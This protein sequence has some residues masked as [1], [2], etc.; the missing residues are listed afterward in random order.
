MDG[1]ER[2]GGTAVDAGSGALLALILSQQARSRAELERRSGLSRAT[3]AQRLASLFAAGLVR[4]DEETRATG[5]RPA[6]MLVLD[7]R[8]ACV[9]A[10]DIGETHLSVA[11]ADLAPRI[12][13]RTTVAMD[14]ASGPEPILG[15]IATAAAALLDRHAVPASR[16]LGLGLSLPAP[17]NYGRGRVAGPSVMRAW[18]DFDIGGW[19]GGRLGIA[20]FAD[21]DVNLMALAEHR[22]HWPAVEHFFYIKVGTGIGS[23]IITEGRLFRG[24]QGAAGDIGHIQLATTRDPPLCR[25]GKL[26]CV[27]ARAAGWAIA[28]DLT[29]I[30]HPATSARDVVAILDRGVPDAIR[31]VRGAARVVGEVAA[32]IV[33]VLN[34]QVIVI[35][36]TMARAEEHLLAGV[37]ELVNQRCLPL[38]T[39]HLE[40][41][42]ARQR[43]DAGLIGAAE[44]VVAAQLEPQVI[45]A[46]VERVRGT[47]RA[48]R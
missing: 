40:I 32:D 28:R 46:T 2:R 30:G 13:D 25:C 47:A 9:L 1:S 26:G 20:T 29:R 31:L 33:S 34:P 38:A 16:V 15:A 22:L 8:F 17:V 23:G 24:A 11:L 48:A 5:G 21:N 39:R 44:L 6:R 7:E 18:D 19:L 10:A 37:R 3:V 45:A 36:G 4:E 42:A 41:H 27:E 12:L 14:V 35:G 43:E